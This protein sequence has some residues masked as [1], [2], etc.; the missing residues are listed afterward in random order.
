MLKNALAI[1]IALA[2]V[3]MFVLIV[4]ANVHDQLYCVEWRETGRTTCYDYG[5]YMTCEPEK[6][7]VR[8]RD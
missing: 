4:Y 2:W 5:S 6:E 3:V 8:Y 7:C 1:I